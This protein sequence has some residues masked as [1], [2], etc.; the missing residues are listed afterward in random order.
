MSGLWL[1][2]M[3]CIPA[4]GA[5]AIMLAA[6]LNMRS[7]TVGLSI[8]LMSSGLSL[9]VLIFLFL[10]IAL[11]WLGDGSTY[12]EVL[13]WMESFHFSYSLGLDGT[14]FLPLLLIGVATPILIASEWDRSPGQAGYSGL[15]LFSQFGLQGALCSQDLFIQFLFWT[16]AGVPIFFLLGV[17]GGADREKAMIEQ[18]VVWAISS[19]LLL[20][21]FSLAFHF[22]G[23]EHFTLADLSQ[24][25]LEK[26]TIQWL[27]Y[28]FNLGWVC[29]I[30]ISLAFFLRI[31]VWPFDGWLHH[32][33]SQ[34]PSSLVAL[35]GGV[36]VPTAA[37][38]YLRISSFLFPGLLRDSAIVLAII[39]AINLTAASLSIFSQTHL[40]RIISC[41]SV[42]SAGI[43]L[44]GIGS[45]D[46]SGMSGAIFLAF[47]SGL[48]I[49]GLGLFS[50]SIF[51]RAG[52]LEL[53]TQSGTTLIE[54][55]IL[56]APLLGML[57]T[58]SF[59][60]I[61]GIPGTVGFVSQVLLVLGAYR[62]AP[63]FIFFILMA[64]IFCTFFVFRLFSR[65]L[66][67]TNEATSGV[68]SGAKGPGAATPTQHFRISDLKG[69]ER[70]YCIPLLLIVF[71]FG[72]Y[73]RPLLNF[74]KATVEV[75]LKK[76]NSN[77]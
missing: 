48:G 1:S 57:V 14:N 42:F 50:N 26:K 70:I 2:L 15:I 65:I 3:V 5:I 72:V 63:W 52:T 35:Q 64:E 39:G 18:V 66:L 71:I 31:P 58:I 6:A 21:G 12:Q 7:R 40:N 68:G 55:S 75:Q 33:T 4:L 46:L 51:R 59:V 56:S 24:V 32:L 27:G 76:L 60:C 8:A 11:G 13:G 29:F 37:M 44:M 25:G 23:V 38:L 45:S 19:A 62:S 36:I 22:S 54:S 53:W 73:P 10:S 41:F 77:P 34:S 61:L 30:L 20:A 9:M 16:T 74:T 43:I 69:P 17:W 49:V 47:T 28:D 67:G